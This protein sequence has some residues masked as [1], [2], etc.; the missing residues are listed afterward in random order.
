MPAAMA[1]AG[2]FIDPQ[3]S[4]AASAR[5]FREFRMRAFFM[6]ISPMFGVEQNLA[7]GPRSD[8]P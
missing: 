6:L 5:R 1:H 8:R 7:V 4:N 3:E 2:G